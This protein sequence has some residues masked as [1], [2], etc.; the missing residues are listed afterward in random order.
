MNAEEILTLALIL[1][2]VGLT[3]VLVP[4]FIQLR[5][6]LKKAE[7]LISRLEDELPTSV[8]KLGE[9]ADELSSLSAG[10]NQRLTSLDQA[11]EQA[12]TAC[13]HLAD[14]GAMIKRAL[15]PWVVQ[16]GSIG[17]GLKTFFDLLGR[18][19]KTRKKGGD[20]DV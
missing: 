1:M 18:G 20:Q 13:D 2:V 8:R 12:R 3:V 7:G 10:L 4:L 17:T 11:V 16:T 14:T 5:R 19:K 9:T 6:T 15:A